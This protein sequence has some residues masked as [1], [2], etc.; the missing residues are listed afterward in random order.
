MIDLDKAT[1]KSLSHRHHY[2]ALVHRDWPVSIELHVQPVVLRYRTL[3]GSED[4]LG[5]ATKAVMPWGECLIPD[6]EIMI[7]HNVV[8]AFLFDTIDCMKTISLRQLFE[9]VLI[10]QKYHADI[11]WDQIAKRF[12]NLGY[13][14][15]LRQYLG[16]ARGCFDIDAAPE[17]LALRDGAIGV[18]PYLDLARL[19]MENP[20]AIWATTLLYELIARLKRLIRQPKRIRRLVDPD[21]YD[22]LGNVI[23]K[24]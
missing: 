15:N 8:H 24:Q 6:P 17:R 19:R 1:L 7:T 18:R 22:K 3:L 10:S 21:F 5:K 20:S 2:P 12:D 9:F 13:G 14:R 16:M 23:W 11:D 4:V